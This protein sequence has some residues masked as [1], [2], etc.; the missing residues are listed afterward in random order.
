MRSL[1]L[2][3]FAKGFAV[4]SELP[5]GGAP[6]GRG[7][8]VS[9]CS[10]TFGYGKTVL[11]TADTANEQDLPSNMADSTTTLLVVTKG[12]LRISTS[13]MLHSVATVAALFSAEAVLLTAEETHLPE[14]LVGTRIYGRQGRQLV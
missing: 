7:K 11:A 4:S 9:G 8:N 2:L 1:S 13:L 5:F 6:N 14:S 3:F 10:V 12:L